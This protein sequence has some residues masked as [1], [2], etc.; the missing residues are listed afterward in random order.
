MKSD[1]EYESELE[2][3]YLEQDTLLFFFEKHGLL[4]RANKDGYTHNNGN[5]LIELCKMSDLKLANGKLGKDRGIG[6]YT[7]LT[8][9]G[10]ST[11]H[12]SMELFRYVDDFYVDILDKCMC[13][14]HC[15]I[16][17]VM[18]CKPTVSI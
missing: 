3:L 15:P 5:K 16:C 7:C 2:G 12:Y 17:L 8:T 9:T 14:V 13:D 11:I 10:N 18:L 4:E 6:N 1:F